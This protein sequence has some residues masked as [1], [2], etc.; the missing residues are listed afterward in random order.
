MSATIQGRDE[1][2]EAE[3]SAVHFDLNLVMQLLKE[4]LGQK[5]TNQKFVIL[6]G[7][8]NSMKLENSDDQLELRY[9]DE[10][11]A[12]EAIIGEVAAVIGL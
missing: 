1:F 3:Y 12:I 6:E 5:R 4:T 7:L 9:M 10:L 11:F 2:N 8:C